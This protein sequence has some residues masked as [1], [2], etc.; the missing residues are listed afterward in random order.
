MPKKILRLW[1]R[2]GEAEW[3]YERGYPHYDAT[4]T[5]FR[6]V[7]VLNQAYYTFLLVCAALY[8]WQFMRRPERL[9]SWIMSGWVLVAYFTAI[10]MV[11][12]GQ[13]RFHFALMPWI[14]MYA[15]GALVRLLVGT[16]ATLVSPPSAAPAQQPP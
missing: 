7:R 8:L 11:F 5:A 2:D 9:C 15:A 3:S 13:S 10:S 16:E 4:A 1:M 12:S 6:T 14:A